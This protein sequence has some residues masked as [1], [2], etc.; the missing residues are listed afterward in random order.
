MGE[1]S[2]RPITCKDGHSP[3]S[4]G[5]FKGGVLY[6]A[7]DL[8]SDSTRVI[9]SFNVGSE[10]FSVIELPKG[11]DFSSL[12]W[13]LVNYK[14]NIALSSCD[15]Y[16]NGDLQIWVRKMGVWLSKSIKIPSWKENVEGLKFYFRGTI[17][18]GEL[19]FT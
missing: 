1:K 9:M 2:W 7:A 12:G 8:Y 3:E 15:D 10:D 14:G 4:E 11:V 17:G 5:L 19:V 6:Y 18:T 16:D 13:N